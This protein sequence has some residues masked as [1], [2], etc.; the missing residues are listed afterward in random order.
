MYEKQAYIVAWNLDLGRW[1]GD[2]V[3]HYGVSG[4]S[5]EERTAHYVELIAE[6]SDEEINKILRSVARQRSN[7]TPCIF[8]W[9][10]KPEHAGIGWV[11]Q[12]DGA[13]MVTWFASKQVRWWGL[14]VRGKNIVFHVNPAAPRPGSAE[15]D[16]RGAIPWGQFR[17]AVQPLLGEITLSIP[18]ETRT[19][20][21]FVPAVRRKI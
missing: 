8:R 15:W 7:K 16:V 1:T 2:V 19:P 6:K 3:Y 20:E 17:E 5:G 11:I 14:R 21:R 18:E 4:L 10:H 12:S 9:R 13:A